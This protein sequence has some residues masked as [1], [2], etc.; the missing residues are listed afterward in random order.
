MQNESNAAEMEEAAAN[1]ARALR[2]HFNLYVE[3]M[4]AKGFTP[5]QA[6]A[7]WRRV[8]REATR[9]GFSQEK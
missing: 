8:I 3:S 2:N 1:V 5:T 9:L 6:A 4:V 7:S